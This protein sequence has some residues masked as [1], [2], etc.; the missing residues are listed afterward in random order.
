[1]KLLMCILFKEKASVL[2]AAGSSPDGG[3]Q[4]LCQTEGF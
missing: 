3:F 2:A 4:A 1:M